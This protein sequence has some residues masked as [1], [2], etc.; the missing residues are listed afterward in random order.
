MPK[1]PPEI[2]RHCL[3]LG[4]GIDDVTSPNAKSVVM[5]AWKNQ[6]ASPGVHPDLGG[7]TEAAVLLNTAKDQL[8]RWIEQQAPK[9]GKKFGK[10]PAP[11]PTPPSPPPQD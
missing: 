1:I 10:P 9:L 4:V 8:V 7:D 2:R 5:Q 3:I 6:I 11:P